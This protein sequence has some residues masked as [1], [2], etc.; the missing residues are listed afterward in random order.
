MH[1]NQ[2]K[3]NKNLL[4]SALWH[5]A[6]APLAFAGSREMAAFS[7]G[8]AEEEGGHPGGHHISIEYPLHRTHFLAVY[9]GLCP[10]DPTDP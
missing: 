10:T 3:N 1:E 6:N 8:V 2:K 4:A 9:Q 5:L 7:P